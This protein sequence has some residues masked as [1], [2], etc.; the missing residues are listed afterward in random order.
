VCCGYSGVCDEK[1]PT[2]AEIAKIAIAL[3][4]QHEVTG[5]AV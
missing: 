2:E 5:D 3:S 1:L 4:Y